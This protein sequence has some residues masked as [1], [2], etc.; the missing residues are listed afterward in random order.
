MEL[1]DFG[2]I[3]MALACF[4]DV[5]GYVDYYKKQTKYKIVDNGAAE[6]KQV[7]FEQQYEF[8]CQINADEII[9]QDILLDA[10]ST[11]KR[12]RD[13]I[14]WL[15]SKDK[16]FKIMAVA[17]GNNPDDYLWCARELHAMKEVDVLGISKIAIP[18]AFGRKL[19]THD[20]AT[21]RRVAINKITLFA[22]KRLHLLG[23]GN[24]YEP[25]FYN[26]VQVRSMDSAYPIIYNVIGE[27]KELERTETSMAY[28]LGKLNN[29]QLKMV[30]DK[31]SKYKEHWRDFTRLI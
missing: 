27:E 25:A 1:A 13:M 17:Q 9:L 8:A 5:K 23:M 29:K 3:H 12:A 22:D 16:K 19:G 18:Y 10:K 7:S 14:E 4:K 2:E 28:F 21:C 31:L 30:K 6:G 26:S 11:V 15:K 20:I 24:I